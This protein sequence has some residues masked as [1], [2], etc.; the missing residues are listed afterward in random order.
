VRV[1]GFKKEVKKEMQAFISGE[2]CI[3]VVI[4]S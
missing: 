4:D 1:A 2:G 3:R